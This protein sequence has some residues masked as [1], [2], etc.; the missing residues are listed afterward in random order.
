M[1]ENGSIRLEK[2]GEDLAKLK[3]IREPNLNKGKK[4]S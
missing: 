2:D 4:T 1:V 3:K